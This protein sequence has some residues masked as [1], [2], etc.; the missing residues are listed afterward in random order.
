MHSTSHIY[1]RMR[2][3]ESRPDGPAKVHYQPPDYA[4]GCGPDASAHRPNLARGQ[5]G[6]DSSA[7]RDASL[8]RGGLGLVVLTAKLAEPSA[9]R[10]PFFGAEG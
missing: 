10:M 4:G 9:T 3:R 6:S 2:K 7:L 8:C 1:V 5:T